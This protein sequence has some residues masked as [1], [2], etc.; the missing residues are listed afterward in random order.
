M[1]GNAFGPRGLNTPRMSPAVY[2]WVRDEC[3]KKLRELYL[4]VATP[5]EGPEKKD[6]GDVDIFV[7]LEKRAFFPKND[8]D[9]AI[10]HPRFGRNALAQIGEQLGAHI[11]DKLGG[12]IIY[13]PDNKSAN[14]A[15][16]WPKH[17]RPDTLTLDVD[18]TETLTKVE[19]PPLYIQVD[20]QIESSV[21][22]LLWHLFK[23]AHGD[24]WHMIG[25]IIRPLGLT[26]DEEALWLRIPELE[27]I[28]KKAAKVK[29][30]SE[31]VDVLSFI[32]FSGHVSLDTGTE[33][34]FCE[35]EAADQFDLDGEFEAM[36]DDESTVPVAD[37]RAQIA[38]GEADDDGTTLLS[39]WAQPFATVEDMFMYL[40]TCRWFFQI[41]PP[42]TKANNGDDVASLR[43]N[44][45]RRMNTRPLFAKWTSE[46]IPRLQAEG[47]FDN[48]CPVYEVRDR[49]RAEA[50]DMFPGVKEEYEKRLLKWRIQR[51]RDYVLK[52][53]IKASVP[54]DLDVNHR[55]VVVSALKKIIL[56]GD[57]SFGIMPEEALQSEDG[58]YD[59]DKT[60][61]WVE[62]YWEE[63]LEVAWRVNQQ[64]CVEAMQKKELKRKMAAQEEM[65]LAI[66]A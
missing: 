5:I 27:Q 51:S 44:D 61:K 52:D 49:V 32:G 43:A 22:E 3:H 54:C 24:I 9:R 36:P 39:T 38:F 35:D 21:N 4:C 25:V 62:D 34:P 41:Q 55:G 2:N 65:K 8:A 31:P 64:K 17:L 50:F 29:L 1:G 57:D 42:Q 19:W 20:I 53:V 33:L 15:I 48:A 12:H 28:N 23:H 40:T 18:G 63:V 7:A 46:F 45:R 11:G 13:L 6:Y 37:S 47:R 16:P 26:V 56:E 10:P 60:R 66:E 14:L 58:L 59:A 30:S